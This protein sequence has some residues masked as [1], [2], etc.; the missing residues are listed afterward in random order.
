MAYRDEWLVLRKIVMVLI[1]III[2]YLAGLAFNRM[3]WNTKC[4]RLLM[5]VEEAILPP[6]RKRISSLNKVY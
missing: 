6:Q 1:L 4:R 2:L 3:K 5:Q